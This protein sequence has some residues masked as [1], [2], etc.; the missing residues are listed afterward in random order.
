[1]PTAAAATAADA[2]GAQ[3]S[4]SSLPSPAAAV[5]T[6][7]SP[8]QQPA[9]PPRFPVRILDT[10]GR[11]HTI[12]AGSA[13]ATVASVREKVAEATGVPPALQRLIFCGKML[14][15]QQTLESV[16]VQPQVVVHLFARPAPPAGSAGAA[17]AGVG[18]GGGDG[19][20]G[21]PGGAGGV[22][23]G[24]QFTG[25]W[26]PGFG[27]PEL[28]RS[29]HS[30][31]LLSSCLVAVCTMQLLLLFL[32]LMAQWQGMDGG[33]GQPAGDDD[34]DGGGKETANVEDSSAMLFLQVRGVSKGNEADRQ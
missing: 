33:G 34:Q 19:V 13:Q 29:T 18:V 20:G 11:E 14:T 15:D 7:P 32:R 6:P 27:D 26:M 4:S 9:G 21:Q 2:P 10:S 17:G 3:P 23:A 28:I 5:P 24:A 16:G 1:M 12:D 30:V 31:R 8:P 22:G 25:G